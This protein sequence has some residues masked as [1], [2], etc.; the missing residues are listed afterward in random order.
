MQ[1]VER[2]PMITKPKPEKKPH[3]ADP[4]EILASRRRPIRPSELARILGCS[5]YTILREIGAGRLAAR[6]LGRRFTI[7]AA[8]AY[9]YYK[10]TIFTPK[11]R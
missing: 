9:R 11:S 1:T 4:G 3:F 7:E 6:R 10:S 2:C 5:R 8:E